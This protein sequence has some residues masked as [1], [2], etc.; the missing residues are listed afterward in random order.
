MFT[1]NLI[2]YPDPVYPECDPVYYRDPEQDHTS[3]TYAKSVSTCSGKS[4]WSLGFYYMYYYNSAWRVGYPLCAASSYRTGEDT[5]YPY[6]T[7][8]MMWEG[9]STVSCSPI[10]VAP[11]GGISLTMEQTTTKVQTTTVNP[12][13]RVTTE[14]TTVSTVPTTETTLRTTEE[15]TVST[16]PTTESTLQTTEE[17]TVSTVP[18]TETTL[19]TTEET[20]ISTVPTT[21]STLQTTEETTVSTVPTTETTLRTTEKTTVSTVPTTE[22]TLR[23]TEETTISTVPN[24]E[25]TLQ[26]TEAK[27]TSIVDETTTQQIT[28][29]LR[30]T[31]TTFSTKTESKTS[32]ILPTTMDGITSTVLPTSTDHKVL[33]TSSATISTGGKTSTVSKK[34]STVLPSTTVRITTDEI[35]SPTTDTTT[36][37]KQLK[38]QSTSTTSGFNYQTRTK[39]FSNRIEVTKKSSTYSIDSKLTSIDLSN[40][41]EIIEQWKQSKTLKEI[42]QSGITTPAPSVNCSMDN[43]FK[44]TEVR[45][46]DNIPIFSL[47]IRFC[48][49]GFEF[50]DHTLYRGSECI[51]QDVWS[52][53]DKSCQKI[54][55]LKDKDLLDTFAK[56]TKSYQRQYAKVCKRQLDIETE[57]LCPP[58]PY[59]PN[60]NVKL[61]GNST[62]AELTCIDGFRF[63]DGEETV[64]LSC[65]NG[66]WNDSSFVNCK[67]NL[68]AN[69]PTYEY[70]RKVTNTPE[71]N[72]TLIRYKCN[73]STLTKFGYDFFDL[74]CSKNEK[75]N[76]ENVTCSAYNCPAL[77][78]QNHSSVSTKLTEN[79]TIVHIKCFLG[80]ITKLFKLSETLQCYNGNW[81]PKIWGNICERIQCTTPKSIPFSKIVW[82]SK[83]LEY[84]LTCQLGYWFKSNLTTTYV[85]CDIYGKWQKQIDPKSCQSLFINNI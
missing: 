81:V 1:L 16:V 74:R 56:S 35:L 18:T 36:N 67:V 7:A 45:Y 11:P 63:V 76:I 26:T 25:S 75:W 30:E 43:V 68:C 70:A 57:K 8:T 73:N 6:G 52:N 80:Y 27:T 34:F 44:Q 69:A 37:N 9:V 21:E 79:G 42:Y 51:G 46:I 77:S 10:G 12:S 48:R 19:R 14:Q 58:L 72:T 15:T 84:N 54:D 33:T 65:W 2:L 82:I 50:P 55:C 13:T 3:G 32:T 71:T 47:L 64:Y 60:I 41:T 66:L 28:T 39:I 59:W 23:T 85:K 20:T 62:I 24:T 17:T 4:V 5:L 31:S 83:N 22:T 29:I 40:Q 49:F 61:N 38:G 78:Q 53:I